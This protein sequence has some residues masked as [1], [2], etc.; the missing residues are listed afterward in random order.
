ME[1]KDLLINIGEGEPLKLYFGPGKVGI[2]RHGIM[3]DFPDSMSYRINDAFNTFGE[4][5]LECLTYPD[6]LDQVSIPDELDDEDLFSVVEIMLA[7]DDDERK[8]EKDGE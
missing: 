2:E 5:V 6:E 4:T 1:F 8:E 3:L 7:D